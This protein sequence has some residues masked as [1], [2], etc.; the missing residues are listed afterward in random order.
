MYIKVFFLFFF[1]FFFFFFFN[2]LFKKKK[3]I[4]ITHFNIFV[5]IVQIVHINHDV[6]HQEQFRYFLMFFLFPLIFN[7]I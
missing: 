6:L 5:I 4:I 2:F 7:R 1:F 3:I